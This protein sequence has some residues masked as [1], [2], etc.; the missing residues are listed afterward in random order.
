MDDYFD[1]YNEYDLMVNEFKESLLKTLRQEILDEIESSRE[2]LKRLREFEKEYKELERQVKAEKSKLEIMQQNCQR[3][4]NASSLEKI[5]EP[6]FIDLWCCFPKRTERE[7]C[8]KCDE[9]R[10]IFYTTPSGRREYE[11][12]RCSN[13][14]YLYEPKLVDKMFLSFGKDKQ[15]AFKGFDDNTYWNDR[16]EVNIIEKEGVSIEKPSFYKK[17]VAFFRTKELCQKYC[18]KLNEEEVE[19]S[20]RT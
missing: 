11:F 9:N 12:C 18:D 4:F 16:A 13:D 15:V 14:Y 1:N 19:K 17:N 7:K 20:K 10:K 2:E 5:L 8:D 3:D 6:F